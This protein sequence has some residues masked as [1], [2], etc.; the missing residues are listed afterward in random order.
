MTTAAI[1]QPQYLPYLGFFHKLANSDVLV[2]MDNVQFHRRGLQ[3]RNKIKTS[4]G[5]QWLTVPV[6]SGSHVSLGDVRISRTESWQA[7][8]TRALTLNYSRAPYFDRYGGELV[9]L[10]QRP[11][12]RLS[13]L[14]MTLTEWI[15]DCLGIRTQ[16]VYA[17][18]LA[19]EGNRSDLLVELCKAV[20][21][22]TYLSGPGG[23]RYMDTATFEAAGVEVRW[24][25]FEHPSYPQ[26]FPRVGFIPDLSIVDVLFCCGAELA[27]DWSKRDAVR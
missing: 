24:Q 17:S 15:T 5:W 13:S 9:D 6:S 3:H 2:V 14:N 25:Q 11:W 22:S 16:I 8:H 26:L 19:V 27:S 20:D 21:A 1:H 23:R 10:L 12:D 7:K 18:D 4:A